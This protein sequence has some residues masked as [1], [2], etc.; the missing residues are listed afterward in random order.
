MFSFYKNTDIQLSFSDK[1]YYKWCYS[2][3]SRA[4]DYDYIL[5]LEYN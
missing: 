2:I 4:M 5:E 3:V 1:W